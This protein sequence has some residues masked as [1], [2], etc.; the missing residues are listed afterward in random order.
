MTK[1]VT[2]LIII[3]YLLMGCD[4]GLHPPEPIPKS[5]IAGT[6]YFINELSDWPPA[7]SVI[8]IRVVAFKTY[9]PK[10]IISEIINK[11]AYFTIDT[12][13]RF[14]DSARYYID[15]P[16]APTI[17]SYIVVAQRYGTIMQWRAIGVWTITGDK[18]KPSELNIDWGMHFDSINIEVDF[19][20]L[21]P[22]P[23]E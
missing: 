1:I 14:V 5:Y 23:F 9:P 12:L 15:I 10:D 3:S 22:Q 16:D 17:I 7:D 21:P 6:V 4:G 2:T 11:Q 20:N 8:E 19:K 18:T 13:P